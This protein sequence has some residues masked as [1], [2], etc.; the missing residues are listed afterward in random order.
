M[1]LPELTAHIAN[2]LSALADLKRAD[3]AVAARRR[4]RKTPARRLTG[5]HAHESRNRDKAVA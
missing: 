5:P 2:V 1:T 3:G 4:R